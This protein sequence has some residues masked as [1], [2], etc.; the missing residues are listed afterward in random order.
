MSHQNAAVFP[1]VPQTVLDNAVELSLVVLKDPETPQ[2]LAKYY[3]PLGDYVGHSFVTLEPRDP[4]ALTTADLMAASMLN[5][6]FPASAV[7]RLL[8]DTDTQQKISNALQALPEGPLEATTPKDFQAMGALYATVKPL[9]SNATSQTSDRWVA[10]SKLVARK[11]PDLFPVRDQV[12]CGYL[13][14]L[15]LRDFSKDWLVFRHLMR[16]QQ[17]QDQLAALPAEITA[18]ASRALLD[19][20]PLRILDAALWMYAR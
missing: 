10:A 17:I 2:R 14:L 13:K 15:G 1:E 6:S 4:A 18:S 12:V 3:D 11:R 8:D 19:T 9:L 16:N 7:R 5:V 20:E